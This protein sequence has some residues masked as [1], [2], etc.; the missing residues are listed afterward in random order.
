[1]SYYSW[2]FLKSLLNSTD[3]NQ[4]HLVSVHCTGK[5]NSKTFLLPEYCYYNYIQIFISIY[6]N[7][8]QISSGQVELHR[9]RRR[10]LQHLQHHP[11]LQATKPRL[12]EL[13]PQKVTNYKTWLYCISRWMQTSFCDEYFCFA[14][15]A[16]MSPA[17]G[18]SRLNLS[19][20]CISVHHYLMPSCKQRRFYKTQ[21][22]SN[23][24][25]FSFLQRKHNFQFVTL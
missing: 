14:P 4:S 24:S 9:Q 13:V 6:R 7:W 20:H 25:N 1:M 8:L 15:L 10:E 23:N 12:Y 2:L 11:W 21:K 17:L 5:I 18:V 19:I 22:K 3:N 16:R